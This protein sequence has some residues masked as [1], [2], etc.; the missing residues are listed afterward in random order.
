M[1]TEHDKMR[2]R[3]HL[4]YPNFTA[5]STFVLGVPAALQTTFMIEGAFNKILPQAE[6]WFRQLL[7]RMDR[8]ECQILDNS[9][10]QEVTKIGEIEV[11]EKAF[12]Q[13]IMRYRHW[14][15]AICNLLG[16]Q[17]N[18][19]DFRPFLGQGYNG[20]SGINVPVLS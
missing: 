20:S 7:D 1:L 16:V 17:P 11:N 15:G 5:Q 8:L 6:A 19:W 9:E 12:Q 13:A 3:H 18:P 4:G 2:C 14:Q 10:N